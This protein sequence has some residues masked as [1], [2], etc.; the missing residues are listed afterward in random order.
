MRIITE[1]IAVLV[2][3]Y[4]ET[5]SDEKVYALYLCSLLLPGTSSERKLIQMFNSRLLF[6]RV[7]KSAGK[8]S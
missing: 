6:V 2:L 8:C 4:Q 5:S 7:V 3:I 1:V